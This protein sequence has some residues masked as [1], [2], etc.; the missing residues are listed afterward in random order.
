VYNGQGTR[1]LTQALTSADQAVDFSTLPTG[2]Y[3]LKVNNGSQVLT[4]RVVKN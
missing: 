4:Q 3:L 1:V 2:V